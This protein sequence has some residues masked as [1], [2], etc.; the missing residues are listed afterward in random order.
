MHQGRPTA[1]LF[2]CPISEIPLNSPLTGL[3]INHRFCQVGWLM[4]T[5]PK[6][7][8]GPCISTNSA[9]KES[10]DSSTLVV[11]L[12]SLEIVSPRYTGVWTGESTG[13]TLTIT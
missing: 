1:F 9:K 3:I 5:N 2:L 6:I 7:L 8:K 4:C 11:T 10:A 12:A 13:K